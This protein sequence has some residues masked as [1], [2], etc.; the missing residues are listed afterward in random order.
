MSGGMAMDLAG[1]IERV[2]KLAGRVSN[3]ESTKQH[4]ILPVLGALG[5]DIFNPDEVEPELSTGEGRPDYTLRLD[6]KAVAF[7]EAKSTRVPIFKGRRIDP[8]HARQLTRYCFDWGVELGIL[9][10]GLQ[11]ALLKAFEP[12]KSVDE[13]IILAVDLMGQETAE[14][15]ER[16]RWLSR[17]NILNYRDI[18]LEYSR[19]PTQV[20]ARTLSVSTLLRT[21]STV[22]SFSQDHIFRTLYVFAREIP[23]LPA[24]A[25]PVRELL[26]ADLKG[27]QPSGVFVKLNGKWYRVDIAY[28]EN[29][30]GLRLAWSSIT[31]VVVR[32]LCDKGMCGLPEIGQFITR[33]YP[34][35]HPEWYAKIDKWYLQGPGNGEQAVRVF[36]ELERHLGIEIALEITNARS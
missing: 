19:I 23:S 36:H 32:F 4:L 9:T 35:T 34:Q 14:A 26:G 1:V 20:P 3:E 22:T 15:A 21:H 11:W 2:R 13:R 28:G 18:P 25:V 31:A 27:Y 10:N 7:L 24:S 33:Q 5:W 29:W 17:E 6:G 30:R 16:L 8:S 12:G